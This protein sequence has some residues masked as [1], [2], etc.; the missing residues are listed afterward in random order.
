MP[1][2]WVVAH[3]I[4]ELS[5]RSLQ[6]L[7]HDDSSETSQ[8]AGAVARFQALAQPHE[9][10]A[11]ADYRAASRRPSL[12]LSP[13]PALPDRSSENLVEDLV[14]REDQDLPVREVLG[15]QTRET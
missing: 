6:P 9:R 5:Q 11:V 15:Q 1:A 13:D 4:A 8:L 3:S 14:M 12:D 10:V 2:V 7:L